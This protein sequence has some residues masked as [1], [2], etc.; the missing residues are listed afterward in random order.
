METTPFFIMGTMFGVIATVLIQLYGRRRV[1]QALTSKSP[2][3]DRAV[4]LLAA[5]NERQHGLIIRL[6]ERISVMER[7]ATDP[8][9][10]VRRDIENLRISAD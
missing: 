2:D 9:E 10:R 3:P 8:A 5:E 7:I 6:E 4:T 1:R